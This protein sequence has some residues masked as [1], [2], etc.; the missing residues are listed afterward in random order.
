MPVPPLPRLARLRTSFF[1]LPPSLVPSCFLFPCTL[2]PCFASPYTHGIL[3]HWV[4]NCHVAVL[5]FFLAVAPV[6]L[7]NFYTRL[8]QDLHV[9]TITSKWRLGAGFPAT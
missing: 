2:I 6:L 7:H 3:S 4:F 8:Y 9:H 1:A 5:R